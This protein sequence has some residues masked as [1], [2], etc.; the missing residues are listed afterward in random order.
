[1]M[2]WVEQKKITLCFIPLVEKSFF[3]DL[4]LDGGKLNVSGWNVFLSSS[5]LVGF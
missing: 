5:C 1:M 4:C 3:E 2:I